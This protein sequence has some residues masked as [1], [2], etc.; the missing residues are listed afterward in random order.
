MKNKNFK[1]TFKPEKKG[2]VIKRTLRLLPEAKRKAMHINPK[3]ELRLIVLVA[4]ILLFCKDKL[5]FSYIFLD[6]YVKKKKKKK[7]LH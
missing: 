5:V 1:I 6:L 2:K 3:K 7:K 4:I